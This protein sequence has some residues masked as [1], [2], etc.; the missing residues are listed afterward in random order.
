MDMPTEAVN[1]IGVLGCA[2]RV[3]PAQAGGIRYRRQ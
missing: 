2:L 3:A 1:K